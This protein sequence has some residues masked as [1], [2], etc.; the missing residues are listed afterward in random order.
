MTVLLAVRAVLFY[1]KHSGQAEHSSHAPALRLRRFPEKADLHHHRNGEPVQHH[2]L[3]FCHFPMLT[4]VL[5]LDKSSTWIRGAM[6]R[7]VRLFHHR[8][9]LLLCQPL[10]LR[11]DGDNSLVH[12]SEDAA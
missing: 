1:H 5:L 6:R 2:G 3:P 9:G 4:C 8:R 7:M 10:V 12:R 11:D